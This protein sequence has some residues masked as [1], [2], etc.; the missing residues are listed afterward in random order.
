MVKV[1]S[2]AQIESNYRGAAGV[3]A[4]RYRESIPTVEYQAAS[5]AGQ[6]LYEEKMMDITVLQRRAAGVAKVSDAEFRQAMTEKGAGVIQG[7][8]SAAAG[9]MAAEF[10]PFR[11]GLATLDLPARVADPMQNVDNR[12]KPVVQLMVDI[13]AAQS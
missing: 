4:T 7:R 6:G 3:A 1:K 8:M 5:L 11:Q 10:E 13:K 2:R 12:L 9:K